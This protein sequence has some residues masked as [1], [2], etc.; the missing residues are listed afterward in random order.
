[1]L[2]RFNPF[3]GNLDF[4][5]EDPFTAT[6]PELD[7]DPVS[8]TAEQ[9]WVLRTVGSGSGGGKIQAFLGLGFPYLSPATGSSTTYQLSYRN[10]AGSTI[11]TTLS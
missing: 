2:T 11:R 9:V 5:G 6:I 10:N 3:T 4:L 1:M 7:A 8:P